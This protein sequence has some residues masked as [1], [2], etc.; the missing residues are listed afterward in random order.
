[1]VSFAEFLIIYMI[2]GITLLPIIGLATIMYMMGNIKPLL[3]NQKPT[4]KLM[5]KEDPN[6]ANVTKGWIRLINQ[7]QPKM[8]E[9]HSGHN[10][11]GGIISGI[12]SYVSGGNNNGNNNNSNNTNNKN[13]KGV[14]YAVLK[15]GILS[16]YESEKQQE[17]IMSLSLQDYHVSL[18]PPNSETKPE[19]EIYGR[20]AVIRLTPSN[21]QHNNINNDKNKFGLSTAYTLSED[22]ITS[23]PSRILYLT[24]ARNIDKEDWYFSLIKAHHILYKDALSALEN[25][26]QY[27]MMDNTHFD[28]SALNDLIQQ[29][30]STPNC[31]QTAWINAILGRLFLGMYKTDRLKNIVEMKIRKKID[32]TKRPSFLDEIHVRDVDV[33]QSVPFITEPQLLSLTPEGEVIVEAKIEYKGGLTI[34]IETD[35]NWSY[36]SRMKPIRMNLVLAVSLKRLAGKMMFKLKAPPTNRFWLGF[37]EMPEMEWKITPIV[38][39]KTIKLGIITNAIESRIREVMAETFVLPNMEDTAF[40]SS[41]GKGGIFGEYVKVEIKNQKTQADFAPN[42]DN[43]KHRRTS[44]NP[45]IVSS[46]SSKCQS[47]AVNDLLKEI[48]SVPSTAQKRPTSVGDIFKTKERRAESPSDLISNVDIDDN[49]RTDVESCT[50]ASHKLELTHPSPEM[51]VSN[52]MDDSS[53]LKSMDQLSLTESTVT[54]AGSTSTASSGSKWSKTSFLRKRVKKM[55]NDNND[56][57]SISAKK[58]FLNKINNLLP[59]E[60]D[61]NLDS[62]SIQSASTT[63]SSNSTN[64]KMNSFRNMAENFISKRLA[65]HEEDKDDLFKPISTERKEIYADRIADMRKRVEES[66]ISTNSSTI[67]PSTI[68]DP[69]TAN[70]A[71]VNL[72]ETATSLYDN[73]KELVKIIEEKQQQI[74]SSPPIKPRRNRSISDSYNSATITTTTTTTTTANTITI[75]QL[76]S[77]LDQQLLKPQPPLPPRRNS[78]PPSASNDLL[79]SLPTDNTSVN[80]HSV[81]AAIKSN[82]EDETVNSFIPTDEHPAEIITEKTIDQRQPP[83]LPTK[84]RPDI[85]QM[86]VNNNKD[87]Q[88]LYHS[89]PPLPTTPRPITSRKVLLDNEKSKPNMLSSPLYEENFKHEDSLASKLSFERDPLAFGTQKNNEEH[90]TGS[91]AIPPRHYQNN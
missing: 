80:T 17:V 71:A 57:E 15:N 14:Y 48:H 51:Q 52:T 69:A 82:T 11:N 72:S 73:N 89:P 76:S 20:R 43:I 77:S 6:D 83:A 64:S 32:K 8:P 62:L 66:R 5:E 40:C 2:G 54:I 59:T 68:Q 45:S 86:N 61:N 35:F 4:P 58:G 81:T 90:P 88:H 18:Y 55:D 24:C 1:M 26:T 25:D 33:G 16:C 85:A 74:P 36:S 29:I 38:A 27:I 65:H 67:L 53:S 84:P 19:G 70:F 41:G 39:D 7:Y 47:T 75:N 13:K 34:E 46:S 21:L 28:A 91:P 9:I 37:F 10:T 23:I 79:A 50:V 3:P 12:Q 30:Q 78:T 31:Q 22:D 56:V 87:I 49:N 60:K 44:S 42:G 63:S